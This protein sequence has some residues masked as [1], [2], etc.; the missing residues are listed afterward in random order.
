ML[1]AS[2]P[3]K[4]QPHT[5]RINAQPNTAPRFGM[6]W[7]ITPWDYV[8]QR[9]TVSRKPE[10]IFDQEEARKK[11][12]EL[13]RSDYLS[14]RQEAAEFILKYIIDPKEQRELWLGLA[15]SSDEQYRR[16]LIDVLYPTASMIIHSRLPENKHIYPTQ[17]WANRIKNKLK[18]E[19]S[20]RADA[21]GNNLRLQLTEILM[22]TCEEKGDYQTQETLIR[23]MFETYALLRQE[24]KY[25]PLW[26]N[27]EL[28]LVK[29]ANSN[30]PALRGFALHA[31]AEF[32][33]MTGIKTDAIQLSISELKNDLDPQISWEANYLFQDEE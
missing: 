31:I 21:I 32:Y 12:T 20:G 6:T 27:I 24:D 13:C 3:I 29:A 19:I 25:H 1:W 14:T 11:L 23:S 18:T 22:N 2:Q 4:S 26:Q 10:E 9:L 7:Y 16:G 30:A 33:N 28:A 8:R 15:R 5:Q 17:I